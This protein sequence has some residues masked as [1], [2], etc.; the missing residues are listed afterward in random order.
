MPTGHFKRRLPSVLFRSTIYRNTVVT[1]IKHLGVEGTI[2]R[3]LKEF[4]EDARTAIPSI[5]EVDK[6]KIN[7]PSPA[8]IQPNEETNQ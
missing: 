5:A 8:A 1:S 2:Q 6:D 4:E 7:P 3:M